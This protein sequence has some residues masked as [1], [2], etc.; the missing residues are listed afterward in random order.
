[1]NVEVSGQSPFVGHGNYTNNY[2]ESGI[3][4]IKDQI[5]EHT[6]AF[7]PVQ[8]FQFFITT[9]ELYY[10]RRLLDLV[11]NRISPSI[12]KHFYCSKELHGAVAIHLTGNYCMVKY[13]GEDGR[14]YHVDADLGMYKH[15]HFV[16]NHFSQHLPN[17]AGNCYAVLIAV[18]K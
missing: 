17:L 15:Q 8:M 18:G 16:A 12:A 4:I 7:N 13:E 3:R 14:T 5:F 9:F 6:K 10:E 1:M 11:H 2:A